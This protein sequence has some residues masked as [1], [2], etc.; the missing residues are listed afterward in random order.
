[1]SV[2]I[3]DKRLHDLLSKLEAFNRNKQ[4]DLNT[5]CTCCKELSDY[6]PVL[7][8]EFPEIVNFYSNV[9]NT[10][11][12]KHHAPPSHIF[13][14]WRENLKIYITYLI[15]NQQKITESIYI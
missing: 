2:L 10:K 12:K 14:K 3:N 13:N 1:M 11:D 6:I 7:K 8:K 4:Q 9:S 5:I 15:E